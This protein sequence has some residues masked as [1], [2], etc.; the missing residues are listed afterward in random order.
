MKGLTIFLN[1][2]FKDIRIY[3]YLISLLIVIEI[4]IKLCMEVK[5]DQS[6]GAQTESQ[7]F[8]GVGF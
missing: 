6:Q 1:Y 2:T 5:S 4:Y 7:I 8:S 3:I